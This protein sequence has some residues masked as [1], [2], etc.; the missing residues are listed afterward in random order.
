VD[1]RLGVEYLNS[2]QNYLTDSVL[3]NM[4]V[5]DQVLSSKMPLVSMEHGLSSLLT[6]DN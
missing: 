6:F 5:I 4:P 2:D 1:L 3:V